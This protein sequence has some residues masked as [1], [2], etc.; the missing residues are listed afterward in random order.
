MSWPWLRAT[1]P[2][3][4]TIELTTRSSASA[5]LR[6]RRAVAL[7]MAPHEI[8]RAQ[9]MQPRRDHEMLAQHEAQHP[10]ALGIEPVEIALD[11]VKHAAEPRSAQL[12]ALVQLGAEQQV[13]QILRQVPGLANPAARHFVGKAEMQPAEIARVRRAADR[14]FRAEMRPAVL[15][16]DRPDHRW[17]NDRHAPDSTDWLASPAHSMARRPDQPPSHDRVASRRRQGICGTSR[18]SRR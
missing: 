10:G 14:P 17:R 6:T 4:S 13:A 15:E 18:P 12:R 11:I 5:A 9:R 8:G 1:A 3:F 16:I 2:I 7:D